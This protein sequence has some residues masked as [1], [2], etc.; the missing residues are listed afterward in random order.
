MT[1]NSKVLYVFYCRIYNHESSSL[2]CRS[3]LS[4]SSILSRYPSRR[5]FSRSRYSSSDIFL[6][7]IRPRI[8]SLS[9][10]DSDGGAGCV[11]DDS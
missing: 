4:I 6:T 9:E 1:R 11:G 2:R 3:C 10:E 5:F 8:R 7:P